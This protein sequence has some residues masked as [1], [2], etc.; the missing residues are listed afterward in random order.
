MNFSI[1]CSLYPLV[2]NPPAWLLVWGVWRDPRWLP[3]RNGEPAGGAA[4]S[5]LARR[6]EPVGAWVLLLPE[7]EFRR[8]PNPEHPPA[9]L[10]ARP[11]HVHHRGRTLAQVRA[12]VTLSL[13]LVTQSLIR[14]Q[15]S[16]QNHTFQLK[17]GTGLIHFLGSW[18]N[19]QS[20]VIG[21]LTLHSSP[22]AAS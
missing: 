4:E 13:S 11:Y 19:Y 3:D 7:P 2:Q 9:A 17:D 14:N 10:H 21:T 1:F 8:L 5:T 22:L 20:L 15:R 16:E 12:H 18:K 6:G